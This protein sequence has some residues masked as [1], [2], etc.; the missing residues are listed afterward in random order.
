M[1]E[2]DVAEQRR[3]LTDPALSFETPTP[4]PE[5][6]LK[7]AA[8]AGLTEASAKEVW[9]QTRALIMTEVLDAVSRDDLLEKLGPEPEGDGVVL[10]AEDGSEVYGA[11]IHEYFIKDGELSTEVRQYFIK[12]GEHLTGWVPDYDPEVSDEEDDGVRIV[13]MGNWSS[14]PDGLN[15]TRV[16]VGV[17]DDRYVYAVEMSHQ[18]GDTDDLSWSRKGFDTAQEA[19]D[20]GRSDEVKLS[21]S[22][23]QYNREEEDLAL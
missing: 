21:I 23:D 8:I 4:T 19:W 5:D 15:E 20:A 12:D 7:E 1:T 2:V 10:L 22:I 6:Q 11:S 13:K 3:L 18:G 16:V 14:D 9:E 17:D